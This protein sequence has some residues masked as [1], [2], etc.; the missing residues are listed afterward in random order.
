MSQQNVSSSMESKQL[1]SSADTLALAAL[2]TNRDISPTV[3]P[4]P[5]RAIGS[6][7]PDWTS[8]RKLPETITYIRALASSRFISTCPGSMRMHWQRP[9][10]ASKVSAPMPRRASNVLSS[11]IVTEGASPIA[12]SAARFNHHTHCGR[13]R[14]ASVAPSD[15][16]AL[17]CDTCARPRHGWS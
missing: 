1:S 7:S 14:H 9:S 6:A 15:W 11:S 16:H 4:R 5:R 8:T 13:L 12:V 17:V 3:S 10:S 2:C